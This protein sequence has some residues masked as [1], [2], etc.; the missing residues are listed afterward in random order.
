MRSRKD[1]IGLGPGQE[2]AVWRRKTPRQG[3]AEKGATR[4]YSTGEIL[5]R[6]G[7]ASDLVGRLLAGEIEVLKHHGS[8]DT[9]IGTIRE[10]EYFG[11]MGVLEGRTRSATLKA[12]RPT[13]VEFMKSVEFLRRVSAN[14][15]V[16]LDLLVRLSE[17]LRRADTAL[18]EAV[19][20]ASSVPVAQSGKRSDQPSQTGIRL[21]PD[22]DRTAELLPSDGHPLKVLPFFF[23]RAP[24]EDDSPL[25]IDIDFTVADTTPYRLATVHFAIQKDDGR[26]FIRDFYTAFGTEVNG[27]L[28]GG[29]IGRDR[30]EIPAGENRIVAG[31]RDSPFAFRLMV[32]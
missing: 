32:D 4:N 12:A 24:S 14:G 22:S 27:T 5:F 7:D 11:E 15:D 16:A 1:P 2:E 17:R 3:P 6:E 9:L 13:S 20:G 29:D 28:L 26:L 8:R 30:V 23:G 25:P 19:T 10:G 31:G 21:L 18:T